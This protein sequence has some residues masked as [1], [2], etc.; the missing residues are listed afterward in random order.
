MDERLARLTS[1]TVVW[2][3]WRGAFR[4]TPP[5]VKTGEEVSRTANWSLARQDGREVRSVFAALQH[6]L[7]LSPLF[8]RLGGRGDRRCRFDRFFRQLVEQSGNGQ[9]DKDRK[10]VNVL[11]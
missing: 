4:P 6:A 11:H 5:A 2:D 10:Q 1:P 9:G 8:M 3:G 7:L